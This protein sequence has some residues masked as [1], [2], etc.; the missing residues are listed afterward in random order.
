MTSSPMYSPNTAMG[1]L[2]QQ[3]TASRQ[4]MMNTRSHP[5]L[6]FKQMICMRLHLAEGDIMP[7]EFMEAH[8]G[9]NE[10]F[11]FLVVNG[12]PITLTDDL[13]LFPSD[14]LITKLNLLRK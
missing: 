7:F 4:A 10:Y 5:Y 1:V 3:V 9:R 11:V 8:K 2:D 12:Q 13:N 14:Q 6:S